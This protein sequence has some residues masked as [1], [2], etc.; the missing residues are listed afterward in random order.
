MPPTKSRAVPDDS[1]SETSSTRERLGN[2]AGLAVNSKIRRVAS[3]LG[4]NT[5]LRDS[6]N[7]GVNSSTS[8]V[9]EVAV[10]DAMAGVRYQMLHIGRGKTNNVDAMVNA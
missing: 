8:A 7:V 3:G 5:S 9:A 10:Q 2:V 4:I 1:R 6:V